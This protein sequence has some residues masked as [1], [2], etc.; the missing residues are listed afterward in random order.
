MGLAVGNLLQPG[1]GLHIDP[2]SLDEKAVAGYVSSAKSLTIVDFLIKM[3]PTNLVGAGIRFANG[4]LGTLD[5][6]TAACPGF[7]ERFQIVGTLGIAVMTGGAL[8]VVWQDGRTEKHDGEGLFGGGANPMAFAHDH[9]RAVIADFLD[10]LDHRRPPK[11][12]GRE[13]LK[14]HRLIDALLRSGETR[15]PV[16]IPE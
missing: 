5:A 9:H 2:A 3:I 11:V 6:T 16:A 8:E 15:A 14:V 1:A 10:A 4:A 12:G 13:A 7:P